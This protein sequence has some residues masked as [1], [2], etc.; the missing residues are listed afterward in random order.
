MKFNNTV[1][2]ILENNILGLIEDIVINGIG[3]IKAKTDTGNEAY[4]VLHGKNIKT[5]GE[6]VAFDCENG[7]RVKF[8]LKEMV[9]IHYGKGKID[10]RPV[11]LCDIEINGNKFFK[12][13]FSIAD[14]ESNNYKVLLGQDFIKHNGGLVDIKKKD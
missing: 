14:R 2:Y 11:A 7:N 8:P 4:N 6:Y 9:K 10:N 3:K 5:E 12:V 1:K 13:P